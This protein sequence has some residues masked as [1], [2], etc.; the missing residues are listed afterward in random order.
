[1]QRILI[2]VKIALARV[3]K[4]E[5]LSTIAHGIGTLPTSTQTRRRVVE[6]IASDHVTIRLNASYAK[7]RSLL[8]FSVFFIGLS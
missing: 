7:Q 4:L 6:E 8:L 3:R 1:V 2:T 5:I